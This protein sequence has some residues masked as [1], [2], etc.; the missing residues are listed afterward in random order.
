M[1]KELQGVHVTHVS[2]VSKGANLKRFFFMKS[3][4]EKH[5]NP[6]QIDVKIVKSAGM[7][8]EEQRLVYGV[9][10]SPDEIDAHGHTMTAET[11]QKAC[12]EFNES[13]RKIDKQH[14]YI[15]G[16]GVVVESY[17]LLKDLEFGEEVIT[18]GSWVLV[19]RA[20][21]ETWSGVK[22][23][24]YTGYSLA[25]YAEK[26]IEM[27]LNEDESSDADSKDAVSDSEDESADEETVVVKEESSEESC[28]A[29]EEETDET[30]QQKVEKTNTV[31]MTATLIAKS[32]SMFGEKMKEEMNLFNEAIEKQNELI[33]EYKCRIESLEKFIDEESGKRG[34]T[35]AN[36]E[37][38]LKKLIEV[39]L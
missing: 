27:A 14:D 8:D 7:N 38:K 34:T 5:D 21:E 37:S 31:D 1:P 9:V 16:A 32:I 18:E 39:N 19:T 20:N 35:L 25:G 29:D 36:V 30:K 3:A 24:E 13:Y 10:Y 12:H 26:V 22:S 28:S 6:I 33:N 4:E 15:E 2:Y 17:Q 11:I 23:G